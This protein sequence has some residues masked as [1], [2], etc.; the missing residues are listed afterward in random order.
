LRD[1]KGLIGHKPEDVAGGFVSR[2]TPTKPMR[3][4]ANRA[5]RHAPVSRGLF[6]PD[7]FPRLQ[8]LTLEQI[9]NGKRPNLPYA[10]AA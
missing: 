10:K 9:L 6:T 5:G 3:E 8:I 7:P 2:H 1:L 4:F